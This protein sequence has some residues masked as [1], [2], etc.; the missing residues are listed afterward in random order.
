[1]LYFLVVKQRGIVIFS[2]WSI[3]NSLPSL[4]AT[5]DVAALHIWSL[6][7]GRW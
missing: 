6:V 1:M 7:F 2:E 3:V 4:K 5:A